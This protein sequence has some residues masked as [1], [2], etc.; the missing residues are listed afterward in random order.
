MLPRGVWLAMYLVWMA[1]LVGGLAWGRQAALRAY[2]GA[3]A[4]QQWEEFRRD[5]ARLSQQGP[6]ERRQPASAEPPAL[7]L[8]RDYFAVCL[9]ATLVFGSLLFVMLAGA[10][11]GALS[12]DFQPHRDRGK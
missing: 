6:V 12:S 1:L 8:M 9:A 10:V 3:E 4:K 2:S 11:R 7:V 5:M